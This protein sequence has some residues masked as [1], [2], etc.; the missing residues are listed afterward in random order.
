M[1]RSQEDTKAV[2]LALGRIF[3]LASRPEQP[4]DVAD[5]ERCRRVILDILAPI[6]VPLHAAY[7]S[8]Y[9]AK[10]EPGVNYARDR[11]KGAQGD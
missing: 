3:R 4:G 2:E 9:A 10:E 7:G 1:V 8:G 11:N 6:D 5:Y